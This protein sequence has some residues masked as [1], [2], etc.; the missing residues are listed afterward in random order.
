MR[1]LYAGQPLRAH[2][3]VGYEMLPAVSVY[4]EDEPEPQELSDYYWM[5][6][7]VIRFPNDR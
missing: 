3:W 5:L 7:R 6:E 1:F 4:P 2:L